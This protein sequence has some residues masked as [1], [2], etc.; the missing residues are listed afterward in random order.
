MPVFLSPAVRPRTTAW[1]RRHRARRWLIAAW[2]VSGLAAPSSAADTASDASSSGSPRHFLDWPHDRL[3]GLVEDVAQ[4]TD[5]LFSGNR[6]Y[7]APTSSYLALGAV[8]S[9]Y[10]PGDA[11]DATRPITRLK[12]SLPRTEER[13]QLLVDRGLTAL[14]R[15]DAE[16]DADATAGQSSVDDSPFGALRVMLLDVFRLRMHA[17]V[18]ARFR[19]P[20]D[21]FARVRVDRGWTLGSWNAL[22]SETLLYARTTRFQ[23]A[24]QVVFH[25]PLGEKVSL[26]LVTDA[27]W[28]AALAGFDL[29]Q[30][31]AVLWRP[32]ERV[33]YGAE[34]GVTGVTRPGTVVTNYALTLRARRRL[35]RDWLVVEARPQLVY[36]RSLGFRPVPTLTLQ[37]EAFFGRGHFDN[38]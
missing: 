15:S 28:R 3:S 10:R 18:G 22:V 25:R 7:D 23:A 6:D 20:F 9:A 26:S 32:S 13:L 21:P 31:A 12:L 38:L 2:C 11:P 8:H 16:R 37:V 4:G 5:S 33:L 36:P 14:T 30:N 27:T 35:Y 34:F 1:D 17:D 24:T 29:R 19:L